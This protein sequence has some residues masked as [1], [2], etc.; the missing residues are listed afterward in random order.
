MGIVI[1]CDLFWYF[2]G[3]HPLFKYGKKS[4]KNYLE[5]F[6]SVL[7]C[8]LDIWCRVGRTPGVRTPGVWLSDFFGVWTPKKSDSSGVRTPT[9]FWSP[10]SQKK[11]ESRTPG[12]QTPTFWSQKWSPDSKKVGLQWIP[13][14]PDLMLLTKY[15]GGNS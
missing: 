8:F 15:A 13:A 10:D 11:S 5:S 9:F 2:Y 3:P 6:F 14:N 12:V 4:Q 7:D 1:S